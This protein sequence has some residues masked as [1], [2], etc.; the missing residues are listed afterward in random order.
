[1]ALMA[2]TA[3]GKQAIALDLPDFG[4]IF[5]LASEQCGANGFLESTIL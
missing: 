5:G 1:M 2:Q 4:G 3:H